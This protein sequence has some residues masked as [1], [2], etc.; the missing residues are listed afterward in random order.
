M[1]N[2]HLPD[3]G[4]TD[5]GLTFASTWDVG[6]P[7]RQRAAVAVIEET[8]TG[9]EWPSADLYSYS[10]FAGEDGRTL[11]HYSQWSGEEAYQR[12][13]REKRDERNAVVDAAVPGV[14]RLALHRYTHYRSTGAPAAVPPGCVV[15]TDVEFDGPDPER[16][17]AWVDAAV[18]ADGSGAAGLGTRH[19]HVSLDGSR[20]LV[21]ALWESAEHHA[22]APGEPGGPGPAVSVRRYAPALS[23]SAGA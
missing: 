5:V 19:F 10:V 13:F 4:R 21:Y 20:V 8:W 23:L 6:T 17:R 9:R 16:A 18:A 22:A 1:T 3:A 15:L 2:H 14:E 7:E 12:Y 11:A